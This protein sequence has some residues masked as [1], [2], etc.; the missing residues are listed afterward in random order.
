MKNLIISGASGYIGHEFIKNIDL[1]F[2]RYK[3]ID[4]FQH[5]SGDIFIHLAGKAHDQGASWK[6]FEEGN[7][8]LTQKIIYECKASGISKIIFMSSS[9]VY[10]ENSITPF[11]EDSLL[12]PI[13][14]YGKSKLIAEELIKNSGLAYIIFRPPLVIA[15]GAKGNIETLIKFS[16]RGIPLPS[17]IDNKRSFAELSFIVDILKNAADDKFE[18]NQI[19]NLSNLDFS[20]SELFR[21]LGLRPL[22]SYPKFIFHFLPHKM[23]EKLIGTFQIDSNKLKKITQS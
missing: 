3:R 12:N 11:K 19:Y 14:D 22:V 18:W 17:N 6:D 16:K 9:K 15:R 20:T 8:Q 23:K 10:G 13:S 4:G 21:Y 5:L 2:Q 7:I 1:N